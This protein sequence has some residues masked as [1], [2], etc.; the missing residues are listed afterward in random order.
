VVGEAAAEM[1]NSGNTGATVLPDTVAFAGLMAAMA[2]AATGGNPAQIAI[3][4]AQGSSA[5]QNNQAQ[6]FAAR[7][8]AQQQL[9]A[10]LG[11]GAA[12]L[13][14]RLK[15]SGVDS[16]A[17]LSE[18]AQRG[19][20]A[21]PLCTLWVS[22]AMATS[23]FTLAKPPA[24]AYD[25]NG[26]KAPGQPS[27]DEG[28]VPPKGGD[29]WV[30]NPNGRGYGWLDGKGNVWVPTGPDEGNRGDAHGG[31]H[32]DVQRPSGGSGGNVYPGGKTRP[33]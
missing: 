31:P 18:L 22:A 7:S 28:F 9:A 11:I 29:Q 25:P 6:A 19:C 13:L 23:P 15:E 33:H 26:P 20:A 8:A 17:F 5:A 32:W 12:D 24:N 3:A 4:Q 27:G 21:M 2:V 10:Q 16:V 14:A 1:Y 30:P